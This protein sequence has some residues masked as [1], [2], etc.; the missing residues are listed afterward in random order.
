MTKQNLTS[1]ADFNFLWQYELGRRDF[2][3]D[4][5]ALGSFGL[6]ALAPAS[7]AQTTEFDSETVRIGYLPIA[8][9]TA[10]LIADAKGYFTDEG[11]SVA[12]PERVNSWT[13]LVRNFFTRRYNLVHLLK[14]IPIWMRYHFD[15][16]IKIMSWA[17][18]NG[19]AVVTGAHIQARSFA[20]LGGKQIAVPYWFSLHNVILQMAL[21]HVGLTPV[22]RYTHEPIADHEVN[23]RLLPPQLMVWA[24]QAKNIDAYIVAEP[25]N[26]KG[27]L[28]AG[29]NLLRFTGDIW[30]NHPCCVVCMDERDVSAKPAWT[31]K[32]LNAIVRAQIFAQQNKA[33][34]AKILSKAGKAYI[35]A[36]ES[37]MLKAMRYYEQNDNYLQTNAIQH[38]QWGNSRIDFSPW[39]YPSATRFLVEN[40][41][42]TLI[43]NSDVNFLQ[44]LE[45]D[46]VVND[47]VNYEFVRNAMQQ[48][49]G[50]Q[51]VPGVDPKNPFTR[52][53]LIVL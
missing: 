39:P 26:A 35:P 12:P 17:H 15:I 25:I 4:A 27:E 50:W 2:L 42:K 32:I 44:T 14:P 28:Q 51:Q 10:L 40:M 8:D 13:E 30:R 1:E 34:T 29:A 11:L 9:A 7:Q 48:H 16:P 45:P 33:Q 20:D 46:F 47:L 18:I 3:L 49:D 6:S 31:Q 23:L 37:L 53:E 19:S 52:E 41:K 22:I 24:L 5:L 38:P 36:P 21:R 43:G